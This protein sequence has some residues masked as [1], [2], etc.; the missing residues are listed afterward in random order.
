M[1]INQQKFEQLRQLE[2]KRI[3]LPTTNRLKKNDDNS[4][5]YGTLNFPFEETIKA[6]FEKDTESQLFYNKHD[7]YRTEIKNTTSVWRSVKTEGE[8]DTIRKWIN[9]QGTTVFIRSLL[10]TCIALDVNVDIVNEVKTE[11]GDLEDR[12]KRNR[13]ENAMSALVDLLC[14]KITT[15]RKKFYIAAVPANRDKDFDLPRSLAQKVA[16]R[17]GCVNITDYFVYQNS[18]QALKST[19]IA[20][21]WQE[22]EKANLVFK[23]N[24]LAEKPIIL[25]DDK[26][27]SGTTLHYVASKL[28]Q[29]GFDTIHGLT[30]VKT[31]SDDD[32]Q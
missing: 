4:E 18:K 3:Y 24:N 5:Y 13:N 1:K 17:L 10:S 14:H 6:I 31:M 15:N 16:N 20:D 28:Q 9:E 7:N 8:F 27:Q 29:A 19:S 22:L 12:A 21:K 11:I 23:Q 30:I 32:N 26:Y 25:L 2:P